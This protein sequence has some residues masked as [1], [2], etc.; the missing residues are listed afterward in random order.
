MSIDAKPWPGG[1]AGSVP[2]ASETV[3]GKIRIA[4]SDEATTG[5]DDTIAMTP[6]TVKERIDAAITGGIQYIGTFNATTGLPSLANAEQGDLYKISTV[7]TIYGRDWAVGDHLIINEDMG[8]TVSNGKIDKVDNTEAVTSVNTLTGAVV[9]SADDLEGDHAGVNYTGLATDTI[10]VHLSGIDTALG[11]VGGN[12]LVRADIKNTSFNADRNSIY[13]IGTDALTMTMPSS[14]LSEG[15]LIGVYAVSS[16]EFDLT[17]SGSLV[18]INASSVSSTTIKVNKRSIMLWVY[19]ASTSRWFQTSDSLDTGTSSDAGIF[20]VATNAEAEAATIIDKVLVPGLMPYVDLSTLDNDLSADDFPAD[21][22]AVNYTPSNANIDG[23]LSGIDSALASAGGNQ[24]TDVSSQT[25]SS[26]TATSNKIYVVGYTTGTQT[27]TFPDASTSTDGDLIGLTSNGTVDYSLDLVSSDGSTNDLINMSNQTKGGT[28]GAL[29]ISVKQE[30]IFFGCDGTRWRQLSRELADVAKTGA[31][32]DLSGTPTLATV[33]TTGAYADLSGTP[34]LATV[35]TTG[36]YADLSGTPTLGTAAAADT[37]DFLASTAALND[38]SDVSYTAGAGIDNYVL[39]YDHSATSWGAEAA[40]TA[41][42]ASETVAGVIEIAT[43]AEAATGTATDKALVPSNISSVDLSQADNTTS[44][45]ISGITGESLNDLSDVAYTAGAGI[46][47]YVLTYDHST[48]SWGAEAAAGGG[49]SAVVDD[50]TPQ[51]GGALDVNGNA[52][53][54]ASNGD[55]TINPD[56]TGD[57]SVGADIIPD[58]DATHTIGDEDNRFISI[59]SD[60]NGAVRF[61][62]KNDHGSAIT[63][64]QVVYI[65]GVSGTVPTV[66]LAQA[67]SASTMPAFGLAL[68][69]ANDQADVEI[70]TF[71]NLTDYDTTTFSLSAND[72]VYV[73]SATA[74]ALTNSAPTGEANLIQNIGRVVRADAS[75]GIIKVGGAGRSAATPNLDSGKIFLGNGSNQAV[76]TALSAIN[77]T[78]FNDDLGSTYQ[79]LDAGLTSISGLT[80][81]ADKMIYTTASDTYA[82]ADLTTAGRALLDDADAT[83]QRATLGLGTASTSN[84]GDFLASTAGL[85]DLSDVAYTAGAGIDNYVLTYDHSTTSWGAEAAPTASAAS[86][87]VAGVIEIATNAEAGA[88]TAT[89]KALVPSNISSIDLSQAD[90]TTSGFISG[91]TGESLDDLSDVAY[92]AGAGIDNYVLTYDHSTT[93]WGAEASQG[94]GGGFTYSA[95]TADPA[96]AVKDTHYSCTGTFTITLPAVSG[97]TAGDQIRVKNIGSGTITID[98]ASSETVDVA[99][100]FAMDVQWSSITLV[101]NGSTGWEIV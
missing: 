23:H 1:G 41:S 40:P 55:V 76:S 94:G 4:T 61:K 19:D 53:T 26:F 32:A 42:A 86:E 9:L 82:V 17:V 8:G 100:T 90:N 97:T 81:S 7:G 18:T 30:L 24:I 46:D 35:A 75:A 51:L 91:I 63:K 25:G 93:S 69:A 27:I 21:H 37:G 22:T 98:G 38:L 77:L 47:N 85:D 29:S 66:G 71:G 87:T 15:D 95:I 52:I 60:V 64:G 84:T 11:S 54:S 74:G 33:A 57:I 73:S 14:G 48:T 44:G 31:Y 28:N 96:P 56:G 62:A 6:L 12:Q 50:T 88:G 16:N 59:Y 34:T 10:D 80:T 72:T 89:D 39:T 101:S 20:L 2:D 45:F 43:N 65:K 67:N 5:T 13:R 3:K 79:P 78:S 99:T 70:I 68:T 49:L 83:A 36:A 58:A 92:T